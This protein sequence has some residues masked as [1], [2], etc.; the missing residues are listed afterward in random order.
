MRVRLSQRGSYTRADALTQRYASAVLGL[1]GIRTETVGHRY[2]ISD[3]K[4]YKCKKVDANRYEHT[5]PKHIY[6]R[7]T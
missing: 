5:I 1:L 3:I 4:V 2:A 7:A 6:T